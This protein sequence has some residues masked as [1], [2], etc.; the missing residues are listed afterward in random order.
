MGLFNVLGSLLQG[1]YE[2][3]QAIKY[4]TLG[5][6]VKLVLQYPLTLWLGV[7]GP[8]LATGIAMSWASYLMLRFLYLKYN[9]PTGQ[10]QVNVNKMFIVALLMFGVT[11]LFVSG[12]YMVFPGN[13]R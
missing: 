6:G 9:L 4:T 13:S 10:L 11:L 5:L 2:N 7:F 3:K 8:L 12:Y 1:I